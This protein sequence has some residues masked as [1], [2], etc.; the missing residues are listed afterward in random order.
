MLLLLKMGAGINYKTV[1]EAVLA[2]PDRNM[3]HYVI[4][5]KKGAYSEKVFIGVKKGMQSIITRSMGCRGNK[6]NACTYD[7]ATFSKDTTN[8]SYSTQFFPPFSY[9]LSRILIMVV[10]THGNIGLSM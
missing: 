2:A 5:V 8:S 9:V 4:F 1:A 10:K 7:S 6:S 3:Q